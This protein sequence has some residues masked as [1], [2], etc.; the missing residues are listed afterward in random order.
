MKN[1][2]MLLSL[3]ALIAA[4]FA[5]VAYMADWCTLAESALILG[6]SGVFAVVGHGTRF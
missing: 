6:A 2:M 5:P 1:G 3:L 4:V